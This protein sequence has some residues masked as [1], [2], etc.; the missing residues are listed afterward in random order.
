MSANSER[1]AEIMALR[2]RGLGCRRIA[3]LTGLA[4]NICANVIHRAE[5]ERKPRIGPGIARGERVPAAKLT[6]AK[7]L[8]IRARKLAGE[9]LH[10]IARDFGVSI[11]VVSRIANRLAWR[12]VG[13][14]A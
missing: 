13:G 14:P 10:V 8:E 9:R 3:K 11:P 2:A 4:P 5:T 7:V 6:E 12:H 1:N